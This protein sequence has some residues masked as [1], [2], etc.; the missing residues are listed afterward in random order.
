MIT[1]LQSVD[2]GT[3]GIEVSRVDKL[4]SIGWRNKIY[5]KSGPGGGVGWGGE[6]NRRIKW[7]G[8]GEIG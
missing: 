6:Q 3:L 2:S 8:R 7:G 4:I 1:K 5:F